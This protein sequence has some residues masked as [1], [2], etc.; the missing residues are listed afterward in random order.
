MLDPRSS[1]NPRGRH[2]NGEASE[3]TELI[4]ISIATGEVSKHFSRL[5]AAAGV[6]RIRLHDLRHAWATRALR[7]GVHPKVVL[8]CLGQALISITLDTYSHV[9]PGQDHAAGSWS[10]ASI[11]L[12]LHRDRT[13]ILSSG[14]IP[15]KVGQRIETV[16]S[17]D[18]TA[19]TKTQ[20]CKV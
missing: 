18:T 10:P 5:V 1:V 13:A 16:G 20:Y 12:P 15:P 6:P 9:S 4:V 8:E 7:A 11:D 17:G 19:G 3:S 2:K 14:E